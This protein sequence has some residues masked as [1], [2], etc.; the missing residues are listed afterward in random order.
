MKL[1]SILI[2]YADFLEGLRLNLFGGSARETRAC[3]SCVIICI[4]IELRFLI[5]ASSLMPRVTWLLS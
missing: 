2:K 5:A 4:A 1:M 3:F